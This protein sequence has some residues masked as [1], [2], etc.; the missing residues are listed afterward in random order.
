MEKPVIANKGPYEVALEAGNEYFW[1]RCGRSK[2]QPFC[3]GSHEGTGIEPLA[4][5][6]ETSETVQLCGCKHTE[7]APYCDGTHE[8]L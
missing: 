4:F 1:C 6:V 8:M 2:D 3:D 7:D 5:T